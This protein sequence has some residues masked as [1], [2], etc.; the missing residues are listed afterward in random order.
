MS[1][2]LLEGFSFIELAVLSTVMY[3][4]VFDYPLTAQEVFNYLINPARIH[5]THGGIGDIRLNE[6]TVEL[7]GLLDSGLI[8][9]ERG[10]HYLKGRDGIC[11]LRIEKNKIADRKWKK[12]SKLVRYLSAAPYLE[13][14][15]ASG[16]LAKTKPEA[17]IAP[18][19]PNLTACLV[20]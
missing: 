11:E 17:R 1:S 4:D 16:S 2:G 3:Y 9:R 13:G 19:A 5:K 15:F 20:S 12:F 7:K 18:F 10:L 14:V 8:R 6:V